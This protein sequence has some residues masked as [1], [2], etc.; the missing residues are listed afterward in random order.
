MQR[1]KAAVNIFTIY[2]LEA[3]STFIPLDLGLLNSTLDKIGLIVQKDQAKHYQRKF[4]P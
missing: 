2:Q 3:N 1:V 4:W